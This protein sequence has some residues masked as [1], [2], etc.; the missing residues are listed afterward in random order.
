MVRYGIMQPKQLVDAKKFIQYAK[1]PKKVGG[2]APVVYIKHPKQGKTITK[3]KLRYSRY[4]YT[5]KTDKKDVAKKLIESFGPN[6]IESKEIKGKKI[7]KKKAA[8]KKW[9]LFKCRRQQLHSAMS[10]RQL[11]S[12][13]SFNFKSS[14]MYRQ[15][16]SKYCSWDRGLQIFVLIFFIPEGCKHI[17][18]LLTSDL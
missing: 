11:F 14:S 6:K 10:D 15:M 5:F 1:G 2:A 18:R 3:F 17:S 9:S 4:L 16:M 12:R 8:E 13:S 7:L